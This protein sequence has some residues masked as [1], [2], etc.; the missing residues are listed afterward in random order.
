MAPTVTV[1][2]PRPSVV[3]ATRTTAATVS[4]PATA[5]R[6]DAIA[7]AI[8]WM[9]YAIAA[10][11][12]VFAL[13]LLLTYIRSRPARF[14]VGSYDLTAVVRRRP[15]AV[16]L[17]ID[18]DSKT[19]YWL[20]LTWQ[21]GYYTL[22]V[23]RQTGF[24]VPSSMN[25]FRCGNLPCFVALKVGDVAIEVDPTLL[26][27]LGLA[28]S[29]SREVAEAVRMP[30]VQG[31]KKLAS[32]AAEMAGRE[33]RAPTEVAV[34]VEAAPEDIVVDLARYMADLASGMI[35]SMRALSSVVMETGGAIERRSEPGWAAL[36]RYVPILAV[37]V[38]ILLVLIAVARMVGGGT[39]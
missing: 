7:V 8:Q 28:A 3:T 35:R 33:G 22:R 31:L 4:P 38:G 1:A 39:P 13:V 20:P 27:K 30:F 34:A 24:F 26:A 12:V 5:M 18:A 15:D 32:L 21:G 19:I 9:P 36:M 11:V 2:P 14:A 25:V 16:L 6:S 23:G 29:E 10:L 17:T 37:G